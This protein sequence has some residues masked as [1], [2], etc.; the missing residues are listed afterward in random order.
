MTTV[1]DYEIDFAQCLINYLLG[2]TG[3]LTTIL[4]GHIYYPD[5][6]AEGDVMPYPQLTFKT[7]LNDNIK[8][9]L[10]V[11]NIRV[12]FTI[13]GENDAVNQ[14]AMIDINDVAKE[15]LNLF[16][17]NVPQDMGGMWV[18]NSSIYSPVD[19]DRDGTTNYPIGLI[20]FNFTY[21]K[22]IIP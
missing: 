16:N 20:S 22:K 21:N 9:F 15:L 8:K 19:F 18:Y 14:S 13:Y 1:S 17:S 12:N 2:R 5:K 4:G 11:G 6:F 3:P 10:P 7:A